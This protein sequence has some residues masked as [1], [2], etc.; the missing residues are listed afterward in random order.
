ME[1]MSVRHPIL[2]T[3][4]FRRLIMKHRICKLTS[5]LLAVLLAA[6]IL[7]SAPSAVSAA[8]GA[9]EN[10]VMATGSCG[11]N[12][13][14]YCFKDGSMALFGT[15]STYDFHL[16]PS[17]SSSAPW[18]SDDFSV[19]MAAITMNKFAVEYGVTEIGDYSFYLP[20][21]YKGYVQL[22]NI[23][24]SNSVTSIGKYAFFNQKIQQIVIP[25]TVKFIGENAFKNCS[26][27]QSNGI[28]Y[29]GDPSEL[30]WEQ[31]DGTEF[32]K[33]MT[34]HLLEAYAGRESEYNTKF[35]ENHLTFVADQKN[36]YASEGET[37]DRN[38]AVYY[39]SVNSGVFAGA[40]PYIIVGRFDGK[41][42]SVTHGS[43]G[44]ASCVMDGSDYYILTDN[45]TGALNKASCNSTTGKVESYEASARS[46]LKLH[47]SHEYIGSNTVKMI[48]TLQNTGSE[49][50]SGLKLGGTGD[51]KIGADDLAAIMPLTETVE[52]QTQQVGFYMK[53]TKNYDKSGD[54]D[55]ATLGFIGKNVSGSAAPANF[56]Y[57]EATPAKKTAASGA[58]TVVLMPERIFA[59]NTNSQTEGEYSENKDSGMSYYWDN[60]TL[61]PNASASYS[62][63]FSVYGANNDSG[64]SMI[65]DLSETF[66]EITWADHDGTPLVKQV[67]KNGETPV[68]PGIT[69]T[70]SGHT[71]KGWDSTPVPADQDATYTAVYEANRLFRGH[72]LTLRG[73]IGVY[74]YV[75]LAASGTEDPTK[76]TVHFDW[77]DKHSDYTLSADDLDSETGFY[78]AR[79]N[80]AAAE[81]AYNIHATAT[82][83]GSLHWDTD[84]YSVK[85]Y[86]E[87]IIHA[88]SGSYS[89]N[90]VG[91]AKAMLDYGAKSQVLFDRRKDVDGTP[92]PLA[93]EN[94]DY[95]MASYTLDAE[96]PDM[97]AG[98]DAYGLKYYGTSVV[99][100]SKTT[101]RQYYQVTDSKKFNGTLTEEQRNSFVPNG[102][103]LYLQVEDIPAQKLDE[104]KTFTVGTNTYSYSVMDNAQK[105]QSRSKQAEQD[106]GTALYWYNQAA[107][108][109][110][111]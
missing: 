27:N 87:K 5:M 49:T 44:F 62:V 1:Y 84:D 48:Y 23:D 33:T 79:C 51:I 85:Q 8:G 31:G 19:V 55:Y 103:L 35:A 63:L 45:N 39:G 98:L 100:L 32:S 65:T 88:D 46:D 96:V 40:A 25:P 18:Y 67:V 93:N 81:M 104:K 2:Q 77:F 12:V 72:S 15:G 54:D 97:N 57:G 91:L 94:A 102:S 74:F 66:Y 75:D 101:L 56:F 69:P 30:T 86:G 26:L 52:G 73:D 80:V 41:K 105:L 50:L 28:I 16:N 47:I 90:L 109:Y 4:R 21:A 6:G 111:D 22:K 38:I 110:F 36:P 108:A 89:A 24:I 71:F 42:K 3:P 59:P 37:K 13:E 29:Y 20:A 10:P 78:K 11:E 14:Y 92:V 68:Y 17:G 34:V 58:K 7:L 99:Y 61:E 83:N 70:R 82:V 76:I 60:I 107:H 64:Q 106:L 95:T 43:N 9:D 53:S